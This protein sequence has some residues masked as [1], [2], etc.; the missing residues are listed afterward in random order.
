MKGIVVESK[1]AIKCTGPVVGAGAFARA[2]AMQSPN[3]FAAA[4]R[5]TPPSA[6]HR[7][8]RNNRLFDPGEGTA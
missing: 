3:T 4:L 7:S 5:W 1:H 6:I 8:G 2:A